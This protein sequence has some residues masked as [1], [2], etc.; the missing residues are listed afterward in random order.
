MKTCFCLG[1]AGIILLL[2]VAAAPARAEEPFFDFAGFSYLAGPPAEPGT[3]VTIVMRLNEIQPQPIWP[4]D[5]GTNEYTVLVDDLQI[6]QVVSYDTIL[7]ITYAGG[8]IALLADAAK[9]SVY[10]PLPPNAS[11]P[12]T[13][14]DGSLE[15][16]GHF[17][18]LLLFYDTVSGVGTVSGLVDWSSGSRLP[19]LDQPNGWTFFGGVSNHPGL[20]IPD[21]YDLAWDPQI[22][23]PAPSPVE[24]GSWGSIKKRYA[25]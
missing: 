15:L 23:G 18:E 22:Y 14:G 16:L 8:N 6:T 17:T 21:G 25:R 20:G 1:V 13:F 9:N 11:V 2:V 10:A 5:F 19:L 12:A 24:T 3:M 4:L 7:E